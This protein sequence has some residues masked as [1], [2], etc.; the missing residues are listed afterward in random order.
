MKSKWK[1]KFAT[2]RSVHTSGLPSL[3]PQVDSGKA[4]GLQVSGV[5]I[6]VFGYEHK[7]RLGTARSISSNAIYVSVQCYG[8]YQCFLPRV[9]YTHDRSGVH[10]G[11]IQL[12]RGTTVSYTTL[13][14]E[15]ADPMTLDGDHVIV[16]FLDDD[17]NR[18]YVLRTLPHPISDTGNSG[19]SLGHRIRIKEDTDAAAGSSSR[20][21]S[22]RYWKHRGSY[23]GVDE[24]GNY[25]IDL[26]RAHNGDYQVTSNG[27][28]EPTPPGGPDN[29]NYLIRLP[30]NAKVTLSIDGG[31]T[32]EVA[33]KDGS[34][35][36]HLGDHL[37]SV[38]IAEAME[39]WWNTVIKPYI[40]AHT[41]PYIFG[42]TGPGGSGVA[43][44]SPTYDA[45]TM[46]SDKMKLPDND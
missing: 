44:L 8:R 36:L 11:D 19:R 2:T 39:T 18:P 7:D 17:L 35:T 46:T 42:Q 34:A 13:D 10:E 26:T 3:R 40:D 38:V 32:L 25:V 15:N 30:A 43:G 37:K 6:D 16:S 4:N 9:L 14:T 23:F 21:K 5:I 31:E 24:K 41:H 45:S 22:P 28:E 29:G 20:L 1:P 27:I 33:D 12:P